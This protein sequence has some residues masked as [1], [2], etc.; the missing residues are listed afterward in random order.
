[1]S[2]YS[3]RSHY[4]FSV[5]VYSPRRRKGSHQLSRDTPFYL[6]FFLSRSFIHSYSSTSI[7]FRRIMLSCLLPRREQ[8]SDLRYKLRNY[9]TPPHEQIEKV[10]KKYPNA[11]HGGRMHCLSCLPHFSPFLTNLIWPI[12]DTMPRA[13]DSVWPES[14]KHRRNATRKTETLCF[15]KCSSEEK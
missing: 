15:G 12:I 2:N 4:S 8:R 9:A 3:P 13:Y 10:I 6:L 14:K 11:W 5:I 7:A 1:V